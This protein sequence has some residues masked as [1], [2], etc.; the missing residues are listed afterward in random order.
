MSRVLKSRKM[1]VAALAALVL[2]LGVGQA[3]LDRMQSATYGT[4]PP[5][6]R[7]AKAHASEARPITAQL[8]D[9]TLGPDIE[10]AM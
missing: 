6:P 3:V 4:A 1:V 8:F 7:L 2:A 5:L 10:R 9:K